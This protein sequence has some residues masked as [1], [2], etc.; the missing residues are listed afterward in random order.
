M[1]LVLYESRFEVTVQKEQ[2][3]H[4]GQII[5]FYAFERDHYTFTLLC[6]KLVIYSLQYQRGMMKIF[7]VHELGDIH[8]SFETKKFLF[9]EENS[10]VFI[11]DENGFKE[12][13]YCWQIVKIIRT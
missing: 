3:T 8:R 1:F 13:Y 10:R 4:R 7:P 9:M 2:S 6:E 12:I 11:Y 5:Q